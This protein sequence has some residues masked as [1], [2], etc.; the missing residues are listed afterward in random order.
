[1]TPVQLSILD[2][3]KELL[4]KYFLNRFSFKFNAS[5]TGFYG[6]IEEMVSVFVYRAIYGIWT[7][8]LKFIYILEQIFD[9]F[10]GVRGVYRMDGG[11]YVSTTGNANILEDQS[12][13]DILFSDSTV[14][15]VYW[16]IML[17]AFALCFIVT[18]FAVIRSM[19]DS[20]WDNKRPVTEVLRLAFKACI[21]FFL[22]PL[23]CLMVIK[24]SSVVT[25]S[26]IEV[27]QDNTRVCDALY[28]VGV[29]D[30]FKYSSAR[31][32][33]S[34][35]QNFLRSDAIDYVNYR[36][37]NYLLNYIIAL[38]MIVILMG[39]LIQSVIRIFALLVL[40]M[41]SPWFVA[42]MPFD[43]GEKFK[44]WKNMFAGYALASFGPMLTMRVYLAIV[45]A[46][47]L[48]NSDIVLWPVQGNF[49][50][51][52]VVYFW[53]WSGGTIS[54]MLR[55]TY[56]ACV[57]FV[58]K[59]M[60]LL[61]GAFASWRSQYLMMEVMDPYVAMLM[62][63]GDFMAAAARRT[64]QA[65]GAAMAIGTGGA[66]AAAGAISGGGGGNSENSGNG[67]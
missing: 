49:S 24:L 16:Y 37:L 50:A 32:F 55:D 35:G 14:M 21:T 1:M 45:P 42:T 33:Y 7:S 46:L 6:L 47:T 9:I 17:G 25:Y 64:K 39:C 61:G 11:K 59:I 12:F 36:E 13:L 19:G 26:V 28:A 63:R 10:T 58:L 41:V 51:E 60:I 53:N 23:A 20:L 43:D 66:S 27:A 38:F 34:K 48:S 52:S 3:L 40:F 44:K 15:N 54:G 67:S 56:H 62:R 22:I 5:L 57:G 31:A 8:L 18:I 29:G 4:D 65:A 2:D 30:E